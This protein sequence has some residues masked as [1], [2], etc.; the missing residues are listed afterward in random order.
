MTKRTGDGLCYRVRIINGLI[1]RIEDEHGEVDESRYGFI[2][3]DG[4]TAKIGGWQVRI[5]HEGAREDKIAVTY[6]DDLEEATKSAYRRVLKPVQDGD[7]FLMLR[8]DGRR[9]TSFEPDDIRRT[10]RDEFG[11]LKSDYADPNE[12]LEIDW[13]SDPADKQKFSWVLTDGQTSFILA[14]TAKMAT[15]PYD[16]VLD[17]YAGKI[18]ANITGASWAL[19]VSME[20]DTSADRIVYNAEMHLG[21][22]ATAGDVPNA[23]RAYLDK[24]AWDSVYAILDGFSI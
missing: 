20:F 7:L 2:K 6:L 18:Q 12:G 22:P 19:L 17:D 4:R 24:H 15:N 3:D 21:D 16:D 5:M 1:V 8:A 9:A 11:I 23:L 13:H 10:L 14:E